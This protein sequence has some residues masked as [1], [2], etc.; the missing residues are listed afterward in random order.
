MFMFCI[1]ICVCIFLFW[2]R[3]SST[4]FVIQQY[5][6]ISRMHLLTMMQK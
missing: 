2:F 5:K 4:S 6:I 3:R 1:Y